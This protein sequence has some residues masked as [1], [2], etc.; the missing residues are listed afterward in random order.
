MR[1]LSRE[2]SVKTYK[3]SCCSQRIMVCG[4]DTLSLS[5]SLSLPPSVF[6]IT[7]K[8]THFSKSIETFK[9]CP[10]FINFFFSNGAMHSILSAKAF[11]DTDPPNQQPI[12]HLWQFLLSRESSA[13]LISR[14]GVGSPMNRSSIAE[15]V[16]QHFLFLS[17]QRDSGSHPASNMKV[18]YGG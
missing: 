3:I 6:R 16:K 9:K 14:L 7:T 4:T 10:Y 18:L 8:Q 17:I 5:L 15:V 13:I 2:F 12:C 1:L 11:I